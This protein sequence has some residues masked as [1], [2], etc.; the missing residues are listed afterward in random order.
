M[1]N[2]YKKLKETRKQESIQ[3]KMDENKIYTVQYN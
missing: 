2:I 1:I 3:F